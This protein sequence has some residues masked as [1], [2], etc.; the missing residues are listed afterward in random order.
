MDLLL[1]FFRQ[2]AGELTTFEAHPVTQANKILEFTARY[3]YR[4]LLR[5]PRQA[6]SKHPSLILLPIQGTQ[7]AVVFATLA[8]D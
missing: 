6:N 7:I 1:L 2:T 4:A 3:G 5:K 8:H